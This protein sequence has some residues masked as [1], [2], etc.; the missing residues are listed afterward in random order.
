MTKPAETKK[1]AIDRV[2]KKKEPVSQVARDLGISRKAIYF[3]IKRY[4]STSPRVKSK[5][6]LPRYVSGKHHPRAKGEQALYELKRLI[7]KF[8]DWGS[9]KYSRALKLKGFHLGYYA[10]HK[11][12][13]RLKV[14]IPDLRETYKEKS[15]DRVVC[16]R[17]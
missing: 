5:A 7:V 10:V 9:R 12:L 15:P 2:L 11:L 16:L 17:K 13:R 4:R 3:W 1:Q 6:F 8:P 14:I